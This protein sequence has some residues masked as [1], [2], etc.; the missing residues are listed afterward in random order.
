MASTP[1]PEVGGEP[2]G[3]SADGSKV[4]GTA[5]A[6]PYVFQNGVITQL[7]STGLELASGI[8]DDGSVIF[9]SS[10]NQAAFLNSTGLHLVA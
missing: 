6:G 1:I 2:T 10:A 9:G 7:G 5:S 3:I 8:S 4:V